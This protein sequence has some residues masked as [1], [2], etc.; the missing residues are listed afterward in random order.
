MKRMQLGGEMIK[1]EFS[2]TQDDGIEKDGLRV[3]CNKCHHKVTNRQRLERRG[4]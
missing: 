1:Y 4:V 2:A 3:L